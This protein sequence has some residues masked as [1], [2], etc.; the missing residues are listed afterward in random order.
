MATNGLLGFPPAASAFASAGLALGLAWI[1][2]RRV[3]D[4]EE[5]DEITVETEL[6][7]A[8]HD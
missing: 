2:D 7:V 4:D 8:G 6:D 5:E 3:S 1:V